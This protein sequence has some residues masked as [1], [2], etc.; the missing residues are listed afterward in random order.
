M[1][2]E[3]HNLIWIWLHIFV[4]LVIYISNESIHKFFI[5]LCKFIIY[6][7]DLYHY[8]FCDVDDDNADKDESDCDGDDDNNDDDNNDDDDDDVDNDDDNADI[9]RWSILLNDCQVKNCKSVYCIKII[10]TFT[11]K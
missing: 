7:Q 8:W 5:S 11:S 1:A 6:A 9:L 10:F 3:Q 4:N 2:V